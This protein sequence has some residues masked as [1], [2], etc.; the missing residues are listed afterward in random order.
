VVT[1]V[2]RWSLLVVGC[3]TANL[4]CVRAVASSGVAAGLDG[5]GLVDPAAI[6]ALNAVT[7]PEYAGHAGR[8]KVER[9]AELIRA[10]CAPPSVVVFRHYLEEVDWRHVLEAGSFGAERGGGPLAGPLVVLIGLDDWGSRLRLV[11]QLRHAAPRRPTILPVLVAVDRD[12]AQV[13]V[14]G[15]RWDDACPACGIF[16]LPE[17][18][19]CLLLG[20]GGQPVRGDLD[21]ESRAAGALVAEIVA[22]Y[23]SAG[24]E[25]GAWVGRKTNLCAEPPGGRRFTRHTRRRLAV[26]GCMGPHA[27]TTPM[28]PDELL[29]V[30]AVRRG[31]PD[32]A[33]EPTP[34]V[35]AVVARSG[36]RATT[37]PCH[38]KCHNNRGESVPQRAVGRP[39]HNRIGRRSS[40]PSP[41]GGSP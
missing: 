36:D 26:A 14:L 17:S 3:G 7:C 31:S 4:A 39:C 12:E 33:E 16:P 5:V 41:E 29:G 13:T 37:K 24:G 1:H 35:V 6:R 10:W 9:L 27:A 19:P 30:D 34:E 22:D 40:Q 18:E 11:E 25:G 15:N 38:N 20:Q 23:V 8:P 21:R 32:P 2:K 28:R